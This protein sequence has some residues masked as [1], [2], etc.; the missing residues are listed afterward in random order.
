MKDR[1][2]QMLDSELMKILKRM[3][4]LEPGTSE[5]QAALEDL[6]S[7]RTAMETQKDKRFDKCLKIASLVIEGGKVVAMIGSVVICVLA[8]QKGWF[9]SKLGLG[10]ISKPRL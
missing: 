4:C 2:S 3:E 1:M 5:Y 9:V 7:L 10:V 8:D 6:N